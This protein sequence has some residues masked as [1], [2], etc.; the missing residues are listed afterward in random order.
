MITKCMVNTNKLI[1]NLR[2]K[3]CII[4]SFIISSYF[5]IYQ[6]VIIQKNGEIT[7]KI[8]LPAVC[9]DSAKN[10][11]IAPITLPLAVNNCSLTA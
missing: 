8:K 3:F 5:S 10:A 4:N 1:I 7:E 6:I 11:V 9:G 2:S